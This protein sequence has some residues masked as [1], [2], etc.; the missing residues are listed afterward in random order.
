MSGTSGTGVPPVSSPV[1]CGREHP[2]ET[3][4]QDAHAT[5]TRRELLRSISCGAAVAA[6]GAIAAKLLLQNSRGA[7]EAH[8]C[9][10]EGLCRN[11][12]RLEAC[13]LPQAMS[14]RKAMSK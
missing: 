14:A 12:G 7:D 11:C 3:H 2:K 1:S 10:N 9:V 8:T 6:L 13:I 5:S 4:G